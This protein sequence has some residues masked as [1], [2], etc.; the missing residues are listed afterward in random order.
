MARNFDVNRKNELQEVKVTQALSSKKSRMCPI[1][2]AEVLHMRATKL[3]A[4]FIVEGTWDAVAGMSGM[5]ELLFNSSLARGRK[6]LLI[7]LLQV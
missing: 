7:P 2:R 6:L 3:P 1:V 5:V 4:C